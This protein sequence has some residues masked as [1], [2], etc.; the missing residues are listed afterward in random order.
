MVMY[1]CVNQKLGSGGISDNNS[2]ELINKDANNNLY[3]QCI[4]EISLKDI[5]L[6]RKKYT[7][8]RISIST[9]YLGYFGK[10]CTFPEGFCSSSP[11]TRSDW[12]I[13]DGKF[14]AYVTGGRPSGLNPMSKEESKIR[15]QLLVRQNSKGQTYFIYI[16]KIQNHD[17]N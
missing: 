3:Q 15:L 13:T 16:S 6:N 10:D 2:T 4:S 14:C 7:G 11:K 1:S 9:T 8:K 17:K 12:I 5:S